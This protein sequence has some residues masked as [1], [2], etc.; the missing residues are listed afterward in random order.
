MSLYA[1]VEFGGSRLEVSKD[2]YFS[3]DKVGVKLVYFVDG[4]SLMK[5]AITATSGT[6]SHVVILQ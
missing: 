3:S 6:M 5:S 4:R 1:V 2:A